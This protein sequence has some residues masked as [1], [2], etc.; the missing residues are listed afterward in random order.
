MKMGNKKEV[1]RLERESVIQVLKPKLIMTL[2]NLIGSYF[3]LLNF[4]CFSSSNICCCGSHC[5]SVHAIACLAT[6]VIFA[7][8]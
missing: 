6:F 8:Q 1:I 7:K 5:G 4:L 2:A 3:F